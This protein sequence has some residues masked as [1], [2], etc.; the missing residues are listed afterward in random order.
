MDV[1]ETFKSTNPEEPE[2]DCNEGKM[3]NQHRLPSRTPVSM[4][5]RCQTGESMLSPLMSQ[6]IVDMQ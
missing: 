1:D 5:M 2:G 6:M 4:P 3:P